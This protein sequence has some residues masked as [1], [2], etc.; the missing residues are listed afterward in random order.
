MDI[1]HDKPVLANSKESETAS[2]MPSYLQ[3][4]SSGKQRPPLLQMVLVRT[5]ETQLKSTSWS[6]R[7]HAW[8]IYPFSI[9]EA[10]LEAAFCSV[11]EMVRLWRSQ[12]FESSLFHTGTEAKMPVH[13]AFFQHTESNTSNKTLQLVL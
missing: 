9:A 5:L 7:L 11:D 12:L 6:S 10:C 13:S 4:L 2:G 8:A 1:L 3:W